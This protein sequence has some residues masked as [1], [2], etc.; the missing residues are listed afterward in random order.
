[1]AGRTMATDDPSA[2][3]WVRAIRLIDDQVRRAYQ[4][5]EVLRDELLFAYVPPKDRPGVTCLA[6]TED[7]ARYSPGARHFE[8]GLFEWELAG[9][10]LMK[11]GLGSSV[12]VGGVGGGREL[13]ALARLARKVVAFEPSGAL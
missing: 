10:E 7:P 13:P 8:S 12:L 3:P 9:I 11:I 6:Y 4:L 2:A 1:M 5:H